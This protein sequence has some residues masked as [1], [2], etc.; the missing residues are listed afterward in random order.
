MKKEDELTCYLKAPL[1]F[2][3]TAEANDGFDLLKGWKGNTKEY[4]TLARIAFDI[5]SVP[6]MSVEPERVFS[7]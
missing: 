7:G 4:P 1:L 3:G 2:L 5:F 6:A